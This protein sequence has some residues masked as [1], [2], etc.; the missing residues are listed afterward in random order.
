M[1]DKEGE[2]HTIPMNPIEAKDKKIATQVNKLQ[3]AKDN[4][5]KLKDDLKEKD[6]TILELRETLD[7]LKME[8]KNLKIAFTKINKKFEYTSNCTAQKLVENIINLEMKTEDN[9]HLVAL[10]SAIIN[11][12]DVNEEG[13]EVRNDILS[14][15]KDELEGRGLL[16]ETDTTQKDRLALITNQVLDKVKQD[17]E[18]RLSWSSTNRVGRNRDSVSSTGSRKRSNNDGHT[19]RPSSRVRGSLLSKLQ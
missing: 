12:E 17:K 2:E 8:A 7:K 3:E 6:E 11:P 5:I 15:V 10:V 19:E 1:N 14:K 13:T 16:T 4:E 9:N 18:R